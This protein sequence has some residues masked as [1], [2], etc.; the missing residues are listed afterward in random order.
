LLT[1]KGGIGFEHGKIGFMRLYLSSFRMGNQSE[2]LIALAGGTGSVAVIANAMDAAPSDIRESGV[3]RELEG[4]QALGFDAEEIDLRDYFL[5]SESLIE[6]LRKYD[7]AWLRGGNCFVLR[8]ALAQSGADYALV[9]LL[10]EDAIVYAGYSAGPCVL[11]PNLKG[12][13]LVDQPEDVQK[14]YGQPPTWVGLDVLDYSFVPH[15]ASPGHPETGHIDEVVEY[16]KAHQIAYRALKDGQ[17][18]VIDDS[19]T[20]LYE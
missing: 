7:V 8:H 3:I 14:I 4:L 5:N 2:Q 13:E 16:F 10:D 1:Q 18:L 15:F 12:F 20:T 6:D 17:V 11:S 9:K 19:K